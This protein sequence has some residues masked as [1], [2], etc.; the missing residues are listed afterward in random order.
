MSETM[1]GVLCAPYWVVSRDVMDDALSTVMCTLDKYLAVDKRFKTRSLAERIDKDL[2]TITASLEQ[3]VISVFNARYEKWNAE[4]E[5]R[6]IF[7]RWLLH[8][9]I[10]CAGKDKRYKWFWAEQSRCVDS[11]ARLSAEILEAADQYIPSL[12]EHPH[13]M[14]AFD[15]AEIILRIDWRANLVFSGLRTQYSDDHNTCFVNADTVGNFKRVLTPEQLS[16][17]LA[18]RSAKHTQDQRAQTTNAML[19][20]QKITTIASAVEDTPNNYSFIVG[21]YD[22]DIFKRWGV[23]LSASGQRARTLPC[24]HTKF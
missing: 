24:F 12:R 17:D 13:F 6:Q 7:T 14:K 18:K 8:P 20:L 2:V 10:G 1:K 5:K 21:Q 19:D 4:Y 11:H 3:I 22:S 15:Y 23:D 16:D 9:H